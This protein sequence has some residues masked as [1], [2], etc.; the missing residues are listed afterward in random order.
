MAS[1]ENLLIFGTEGQVARSFRDILPQ[2]IYAHRSECD[3]LKPESIEPYLDRVCPQIIINP[4][5]FTEVD[6]AETDW[7]AAR[8]VNANAPAAIARWCA[9][10]GSSLIHYSTDY[11]YSGGGTNFWTEVDMTRPI[12]QYGLSKREGEIAIQ[13][14]GCHHLILR[15]AWVYSPYGKNFV[16]TILRLGAERESLRVVDDQIGSPTLAADLALATLKICSHPCFRQTTGI[17]NVVN[18]G[19]TSWYNFA[20]S[21]FEKARVLGFPLKVCDVL[22]IDSSQYPLPAPR[23]KNS[24]LDT[25]KLLAEFGVQMRPWPDAL[26]DCLTRLREVRSVPSRDNL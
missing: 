13:A 19:I 18:S 21:I 25:G 4:A 23:P 11:V 10:N 24:R 2:A 14:S 8:S 22:P 17:F 12:N 6:R 1:S 5:A 15:T 7:E 3:F 26:T 9:R 16:R 20:I